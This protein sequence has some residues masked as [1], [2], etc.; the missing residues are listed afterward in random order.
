MAYDMHSPLERHGGHTA[1]LCQALLSPRVHPAE[2][3]LPHPARFE[4]LEGVEGAGPPESP[5]SASLSADL[6]DLFDFWKLLFSFFFHLL[7]I[8]FIF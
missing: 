3:G 7:I 1:A 5:S 6:E 2:L 4:E 8:I